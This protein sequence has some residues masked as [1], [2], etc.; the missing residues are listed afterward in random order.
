ML[1][2]EF[3]K[4]DFFCKYFAFSLNHKVK[5][6]ITVKFLLKAHFISFQYSYRDL[7]NQLCFYKLQFD[8]DYA[9]R[10]YKKNNI[11]L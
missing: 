2:V 10:K 11:S 5:N 6:S 8:V 9:L 3:I 4:K 1:T 7:Y